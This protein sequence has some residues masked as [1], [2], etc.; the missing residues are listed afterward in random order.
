MSGVSDMRSMMRNRQTFY[1]ASFVSTTMTKDA[2]GSYTEPKNTYSKP[3][4]RT[5]VI[6]PASGE[7]S[8]QV[9]GADERYD[10]VITLNKGENYL[11]VG[12]VL[13]VDTMP[14]IKQDG[15]T[16]TPYDYVVSR[17]AESLNV[18]IVAIRKVN[19]S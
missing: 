6:A 19:V 16:D 8:M 10:K 17:T 13:W 5:G 9:F 3:T 11:A 1:E 14:T 12:S 7:I 4:K 2:S 15:S 18:V